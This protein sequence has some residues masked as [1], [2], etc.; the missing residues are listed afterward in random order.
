[1]LLPKSNAPPAPPPPVCL[2]ILLN[3]KIPTTTII[4]IG[5]KFKMIV[6]P[7]LELVASLVV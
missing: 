2:L 7:K 6:K 4:T 5:N 3:K 1:V